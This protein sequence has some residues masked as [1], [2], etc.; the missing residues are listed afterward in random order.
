MSAIAGKAV[1]DG[2]SAIIAWLGALTAGTGGNIDLKTAKA[3]LKDPKIRQALGLEGRGS[4]GGI[5]P[6]QKDIFDKYELEKESE[7]KKPDPKEKPRD[8]DKP[9]E[10]PRIPEP[11]PR[12]PDPKSNKPKDG[13]REIP[14]K[15]KE[16]QITDQ[17]NPQWYSGYKFGGQDILK[18]TDLEK[19]EEIRNWTLFDLVNPH[20]EGDPENLLNIQN[21]ISE[22]RRF[23]N[24]YDNPKPPQD[25][26]GK[27]PA[28][29]INNYHFRDQLPIDYP[30]R[31]SSV[32][33]Q[34]YYDNFSDQESRTNDYLKDLAQRGLDPDFTQIA[35]SKRRPF[36]ADDP[37]YRKGKARP[38]LVEAVNINKLSDVDFLIT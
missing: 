28:K 20:L 18:L 10:I 17:K 16:Q 26:Q 13:P 25:F 4:Y 19:L 27:I 32:R 14:I 36:S 3:S 15:T 1:M 23:N 30:F 11:K 33:E 29:Y 8:P 2:S 38:S 12:Q 7:T 22:N 31:E 6:N 5:L 37:K 21:K 34:Q 35:N 9:P 24:T